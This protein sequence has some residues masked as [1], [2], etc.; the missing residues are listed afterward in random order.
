ME[1]AKKIYPYVIILWSDDDMW[2]HAFRL[3]IDR[4]IINKNEAARFVKKAELQRK[5]KAKKQSEYIKVARNMIVVQERAK[6][7]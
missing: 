2:T 1:D 4:K 3:L 5:S 6:R 7:N